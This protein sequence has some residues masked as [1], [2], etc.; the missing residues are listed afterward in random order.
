MDFYKN[1]NSNIITDWGTVSNNSKSSSDT[2][3][4]ILQIPET[5][6]QWEKEVKCP[7]K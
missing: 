3:V 2:F 1:L 6:W 5:R 7:T 4:S